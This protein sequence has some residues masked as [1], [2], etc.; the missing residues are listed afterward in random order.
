MSTDDD[1][2]TQTELARYDAIQASDSTNIET[3]LGNLQKKGLEKSK[4]RSQAQHEALIRNLL[5][6]ARRALAGEGDYH[7]DDLLLALHWLIKRDSSLPEVLNPDY[8]D[9]ENQAKSRFHS[10]DRIR[11]RG[12]SPPSA[13][14]ELETLTK[15][16]KQLGYLNSIVDTSRYAPVRFAPIDEPG[17]RTTVEE[18]TPVG[19]LRIAKDSA[20]DLED[21]VVEIPHQSCDHIGAIAL[22]RRGKDST[23]VSLGK[24][25]QSEHGYSYISIMDDG[26]ME[27]PMIG[28]PNDEKVIQ[29][30]LERM[31]QGPDAMPAD[32]FVPSMGEV[33]DLLPSNFELFTIG[34]DTLTPHLILRLAG[35]TKS[36]ETVEARIKKAL[37][38][39]L[40]NSGSV[41]ELVSRLQVYAREMEATIEWTE[42]EEKRA[43]ESATTTY[44][45]HYQMDAESALEKAAQRVAQLAAEGLI[46]SPSAAT[47]IDM[48]EIIADQDRAAVL[49]CNFL[50]SGLEPLKYVI[51]D[52]WLRLIYKARDENPRLPRVCIEIRE[53]KNIAPSKMADVRYKS[54]IKT[55]RQTIF[56]LTTQGGSRRILLLGST[57]KWNDVYKPVRSNI[58]IK[59]LLQLGEDE[60]DTLDKTHHFSWEQQRQLSEFDIGWGMII[61]EGKPDYP[62]ELRGA[63][64]G[65]GLGD[66]HWRDRY[67]VAWGA[68]V[69]EHDTDSW[70]GDEDL[71]WWVN[72]VDCRVHD[73]DTDGTPEIGQWFLLPEDLEDVDVSIG[74][75]APVP[76]RFME[77]PADE[78]REWVDAA[79]EERREHEIPNDLLLQPSGHQNKQR[80]VSLSVDDVESNIGDIAED[81]NVP[82]PLHSWLEAKDQKR[83]KLLEALEV[84]TEHDDLTTISDVA[85]HLS[86]SGSTLRNYWSADD[87]LGECWSKKGKRYIP[88][89]IGK[90]AAS[91]DW[92]DI[93]DE[94]EKL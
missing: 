39:T 36:D 70:R 29:D 57:Q 38:E 63:P 81:Y 49:C 54:D 60:I 31:G 8:D 56:F 15:I 92:D 28:I 2:K 37:D 69:R 83:E 58:A 78:R 9:L 94:L 21:R 65:L 43:G 1:K 17:A 14:K 19:R 20:V 64:C 3:A 77:T 50:G 47:N 59:F 91:L 80:S 4:R 41:S 73:F 76:G 84:L 48:N 51:M 87:G 25:L 86:Y 85:D 79:L 18:P 55:L 33:P 12:G 75:G 74:D 26:R 34:I 82:E 72:V 71:E 7:A 16:S 22:P 11:S 32:V 5:T 61:S 45:A 10:H 90:Q 68:R 93:E 52:L 46:T 53:L 35:V 88:T 40:V 44:T 67:G 89:P 13:E 6:E 27:T 42:I 30:N 24:N 62:V 23:L 66:R